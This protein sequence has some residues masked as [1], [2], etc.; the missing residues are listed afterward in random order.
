[1]AK[2]IVTPNPGAVE[3]DWISGLALDFMSETMKNIVMLNLTQPWMHNNVDKYTTGILTLGYHAA[4]SS[5][6]VRLG[7]A[8]EPLLL[9]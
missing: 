1:M 9:E 8:S 5:L 4:W 6:M 7:N 3:D 2:C